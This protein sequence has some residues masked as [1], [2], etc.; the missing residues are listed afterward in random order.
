MDTTLTLD[1]TPK[2][3]AEYEAAIDHMLMQMRQMR[4]EIAESHRLTDQIQM[5]TRGKLDHLE[6]I[7]TQIEAI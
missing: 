2:T 3:D 7:L 4:A 1:T 5:Q 6:K